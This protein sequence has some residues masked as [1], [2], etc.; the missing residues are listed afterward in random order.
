MIFFYDKEIKKNSPATL[1]V[2][3]NATV[4]PFCSK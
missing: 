3:Q 4:A 2:K 1:I